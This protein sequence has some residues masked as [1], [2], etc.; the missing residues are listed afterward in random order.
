MKTQSLICALVVLGVIAGG[1]AA[2]EFDPKRDGWYFSNWGE[3]SPHCVGSCDFSWELYRQTYLGIN[4]THDCV[5]APLDCAFYEIFKGCAK[6]GNCGGM[7]LLA[8]A[9]FKYGGYFGFCSPASFYTGTESPDRADLH[10]AINILQARQFSAAGIENFIDVVDAGNLNNAVAAF[11]TVRD[12]LA[13]GDYAVL[14]IAN[15]ALGD[16]AHTVIPYKVVDGSPKRMYIWDPNLPYDDNAARYDT[17]A[18]V[19]TINSAT[20]WT[21][22]QSSS[23]TYSGSGGTGA[24]CFAIPMSIVLPKS[25]QPLALDMVFDA[26]QSAFVTGP[27]AAVSQI[28]DDEGRRFYKTDADVHVLGNDLETDPAKRLKGVARWRWPA[29]GAGD[30]PPGELYFIRR[31]IG[32][33]DS[34]NFTISGAQYRAVIGAAGNLI[35]IESSSGASAKDIIR[36]SNLGTAAQ[37]VQ[38]QTLAA[39][40]NLSV[41]QLRADVKGTDWR[42]IEVKNLRVPRNLPVTIQAVGDVESV[43]VSSSEQAVTFDLDLQQRIKGRFAA[44]TGERL[45]TSPGKHLWIAPEDWNVLERTRITALHLDRAVLGGVSLRVPE[46]G[47]AREHPTVT[48]RPTATGPAVASAGDFHKLTDLEFA[49]ESGVLTSAEIRGQAPPDGYQYAVFTLVA[50]NTQAR[51][52]R[53]VDSN[54]AARL[55]SSAG[56]EISWNGVFLGERGD[57]GMAVVDVKPQAAIKLRV[58]YTVPEGTALGRLVFS[59]K[60]TGASFAVDVSGR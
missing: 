29:Q 50:R 44:K 16:A 59:E 21:Y 22:V 24:W 35:Q 28:S 58:Y 32:R 54:Y 6:E 9:L 25:R 45:S 26:L 4:P 40:R 11:N 12:A 39:E 42:S 15:S 10:Q 49:L 31:T 8:L 38:I 36:V 56:D 20:D 34:L 13:R 1:L 33:A 51:Q 37:T 23:R 5:E 30:Q 18:N 60:S 55:Y 14:S 43:L 52:V 46:R 27:G 17:E 57:T 53:F 47:I 3:K 7:S 41:K 2:Q 19:M 48:A